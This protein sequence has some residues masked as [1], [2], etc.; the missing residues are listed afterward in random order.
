MQEPLINGVYH[1]FA[2]IELTLDTGAQTYVT[3]GIGEINYK[4]ELKPAEVRGTH[5]Q[6]LGRTLGKYTCS[7]DMSVHR[8]VYDEIVALLGTGFGTVPFDLV[9]QF[10]SPGVPLTTDTLRGCRIT[11]PSADNKDGE[12]ASMIKL[13]LMPMYLLWN[14][15]SILPNLL[16]G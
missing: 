8:P 16:E 3:R 5:P 15:V 13:E 4:D 1:S 14:G 6:A 11:G 12:D 10:S 2:S 7:A 9:V